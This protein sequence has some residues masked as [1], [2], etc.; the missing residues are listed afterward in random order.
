MDYLLLKYFPHLEVEKKWKL[1][2]VLL[3]N[4]DIRSMKYDMFYT[5]FKDIN[6][7][8]NIYI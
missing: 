6:L 3:Q 8:R 5:N 2:A 4:L 7:H 1:L